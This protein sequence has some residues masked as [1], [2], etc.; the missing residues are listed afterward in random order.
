MKILI[1]LFV[2]TLVLFCLNLYRLESADL[3]APSAVNVRQSAAQLPALQPEQQ[4]LQIQQGNT[5]QFRLQWGTNPEAPFYILEGPDQG[6]GFCD[7]MVERLQVYLPDVRH[8]TLIEPQSR[9]R[10]R[11]DAKEHLCYPCALFVPE[12]QHANGRLF[13]KPTHYYRPH[14]IIT[15]P[16]LANSI[17]QRFG[18]P[19]DLAKLLASELRFGFPSQRR[20]GKLQPLLDEHRI[21]SP[22]HISLDTGKDATML[23]LQMLSQQQLDATIDYISSLQYYDRH[24]TQP[25]VFLPIAGFEDWLAGAVS[26]PDSNWGQLAVLRVNAVI[27]KIRQDKALRQNLQFWFGKDLP[28]Y[29]QDPPEQPR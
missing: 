17:R 11:M 22:N 6:Q 18:D 20:Y 27:D 26:C 15:R 9:I 4:M 25:L 13:S 8:Q 29:P 3:T 5:R 10:Q 16:D 28:P 12:S 24:S 23:H 2:L 1:S 7:V 19:V 14:G 21:H